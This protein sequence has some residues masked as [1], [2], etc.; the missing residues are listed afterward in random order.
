VVVLT[1]RPVRAL[2][3]EV[4]FGALHPFVDELRSR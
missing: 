4:A 1:N 2:T 3:A